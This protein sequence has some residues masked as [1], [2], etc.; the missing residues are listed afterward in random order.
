M[1]LEYAFTDEYGAFGWNLEKENVSQVFIITAIL[2]KECDLTE[3]NDRAEYIRKKHFQNGEMKSSSIGSNARRRLSIID[4][5]VKLPFSVFSVVVDKRKCLEGMTLKGLNYKPVFYKFMNNIAYSELKQAFPNLV[6]VADEMGSSDYMQSFCRYVM[7]KQKPLDLFETYDFQFQQSNKELGIQVADVICGTL[8]RIYDDNKREEYSSI[9]FEK[10][11]DKVVR[12]ELFPKD[13]SNFDIEHSSLTNEYDVKIANLCYR[14]ARKYIQNNEYSED[15]YTN[16]R[17]LVLKYL[18]FRF[19]N[20]ATR[21]YISTKELKQ[22]LSSIGLGSINNQV[23]RSHIIGK[24]RDEKVIIASCSKGYKIPTSIG[25]IK[26]YVTHDAK[27]VMPMLSRLKNC[28]DIVKMNSN[29]EVDLLDG[30]EF[31]KLKK[32]FDNYNQNEE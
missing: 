27:I 2:V 32:Y 6:I 10:L 13:F 19:M 15:L 1:E 24:L 8:S 4:E 21:K 28:R 31:N 14:Q 5:I 29:N 7:K 30:T 23:F 26:D 22:S 18:L 25:E 12:I 16:G 17:V 11:K 9:Y 3:F 20:N